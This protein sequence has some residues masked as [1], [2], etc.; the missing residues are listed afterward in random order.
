MES[1]HVNKKRIKN[2]KMEFKDEIEK[3]R[4]DFKK[5]ARILLEFGSGFDFYKEKDGNKIKV[6][7]KMINSLIDSY[8]ESLAELKK[9]IPKKKI[10]QTENKFNTPNYVSDQFVNYVSSC[11][12]GNG[13]SFVFFMHPTM[14]Y[15]EKNELIR[16]NTSTSE[17]FLLIKNIID[18]DLDLYVKLAND[19]EKIYVNEKKINNFFIFTKENI[20]DFIDIKKNMNLLLTQN[21]MPG[22][23]S[24]SIITL[25]NDIENETPIHKGYY[26][27][28][29]EMKKHLIDTKFG[30]KPILHDMELSPGD[31]LTF[32]EKLK[33]SEK[34]SSDKSTKENRK[35]NLIE[36]D[37]NIYYNHMLRTC[38]A[39]S[40]YRINKNLLTNEQN[41]LLKNTEILEEAK[42]LKEYIFR[43]K[44]VQKCI[45]K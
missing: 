20:Y 2:K 6:N 7:R 27:V 36:I 45:K 22:S 29:K 25:I 23:L 1:I 16:T 14:N 3:S 33:N 8:D 15:Q 31:N 24:I 13:L 28:S 19:F 21:I 42:N 5:I 39:S 35:K 11:N 40:Y 41:D 32:L 43:I 4:R 17:G 26:G 34:N 9:K 38:I 44:H 37:G 10:L 30:T 12:L 18:K